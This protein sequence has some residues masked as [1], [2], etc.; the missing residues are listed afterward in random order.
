MSEYTPTT[1][2][3]RAFYTAERLDGPHL[4][5]FPA[6]TVEQAESE[7]NAWLAAHD[8]EVRAATLREALD[9]ESHPW[10]LLDF[11]QAW[12]EADARFEVGTRVRQG[13]AAMLTRRAALLTERLGAGVATEEPEWE[14]SWAG[15]DDEGDEWV[16]DD[17]FD[18]RAA[19]EAYIR[20]P[21]GGWVSTDNGK[22]VRRRKAGPWVPVKQ[23]GADD[24]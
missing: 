5:G 2:E 15:T 6:P 18:T 23:E 20:R 1:E 7:F 10:E 17:S 12:E 19:A 24:A 21:I 8:D 16:M 4:G 9:T 11:R 3:M 13:L 14:Y 22:L